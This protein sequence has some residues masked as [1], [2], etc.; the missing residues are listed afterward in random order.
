MNPYTLTGYCLL[1]VIAA[2]V[3]PYLIGK[4]AL[5]RKR[6]LEDRV[7]SKARWNGLPID[8][9]ARE[10]AKD[11]VGPYAGTASGAKRYRFDHLGRKIDCDTGEFVPYT[12]ELDPEDTV[13]N[14]DPEGDS[15]ISD[16]LYADMADS[17][18]LAAAREK[19]RDGGDI[20]L[21]QHRE[22]GVSA[23]LGASYGKKAT[24]DKHGHQVRNK[25][26]FLTARELE[27]VNIKRRL[28]GKPPLNRAGFAN[29]VSHAA[30]QPGRQPDTSSDWL[31]YLIVYE[32]L[33]ADHTTPRTGVDTGI[34]ITP[35]A[36]YNGHGGEFAGAGASGDWT[37]PGAQAL[38]AADVGMGVGA[39]VDRDADSLHDGSL[40]PPGNPGPWPTP[41]TS[42]AYAAPDPSP[43][44]DSSS[45]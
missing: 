11:D 36:P 27:H 7:R 35:D 16:D 42:P 1:A 10:V 17:P 28:A 20:P 45:N 9:A 4:H 24:F 31:T 14:H 33:T 19:F 38:G 3:L 2:A 23:A 26:I 32:S 25:S 29:A 22:I 6:K 21:R 39:A 13:T 41:D 44:Y 30:T 37:S 40:P 15:G 43:S 5:A 34:T 18:A 12:S 8:E